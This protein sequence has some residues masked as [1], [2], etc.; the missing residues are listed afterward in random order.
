MDKLNLKLSQDSGMMEY[1]DMIIV[2][3]IR[4]DGRWVRL[5]KKVYEYVQFLISSPDIIEQINSFEKN[6]QKFYKD[7]I[8][9]LFDIRVLVDKEPEV[10]LESISIE[11][12]T[13]CNL[14]CKH[15]CVSAGS[16][17]IARME[18][19]KC[20]RVIDWAENN[21]IQEITF[22]G[23]EP[24]LHPEIMEILL[25]TREHFSGTIE[26][27]TN[28]TVLSEQVALLLIKTLDHISISLDGYD[29]ESIDYMRGKNV[30]KTVQKK[31]ELLKNNSFKMISG[32]MVL[33]DDNYTHIEEFKKLCKTFN[34][35]PVLR[36]M[37]PTGRALENITD[38]KGIGIHRQVTEDSLNM[39]AGCNAGY[40]TIAIDVHGM[41]R[42][43]VALETTSCIGTMEELFAGSLNGKIRRCEV[44]YNTKCQ[45][46]SVRY[47]CSDIC[48]AVNEAI[49]RNEDIRLKRC[50]AI[51]ACYEKLAWNKG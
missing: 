43:C 29:E 11:L 1:G 37:T 49:Y 5:P 41:V 16:A 25:Y 45:N 42:E 12:T 39:R 18:K 47:F 2:G 46:C 38:L 7:L 17:Q 14:R 27:I 3:N 23:G 32:T 34:I 10:K 9:K 36:T 4:S 35:V 30:F 8:Q 31:I 21:K 22:T 24:L 13:E 48:R 33:S 15:C 44:D 50:N 19:E 51:K 26:M 20:F 40:S 28:L 6:E